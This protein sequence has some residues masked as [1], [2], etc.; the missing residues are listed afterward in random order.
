MKLT[1]KEVEHVALL[2]RL[3]L[4]EVEK[5]LFLG[6]LS[7]ILNYVGQLQE[8]DTKSVEETAQVTG[9]K[10]ALREDNIE[11]TPKGTRERILKNAPEIEDDL[12][13]T[14]SVFE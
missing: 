10:N 13:K 3:K 14:K 1:K 8:L 4:S 12:I 11:G 5:E 9:I 7:S 6:Q 2:A